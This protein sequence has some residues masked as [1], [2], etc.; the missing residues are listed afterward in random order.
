VFNSFEKFLKTVDL[1]QSLV[2]Q[3][4]F[5]ITRGSLEPSGE[6]KVGG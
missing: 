1:L 4:I 6:Q 5:V 3:V 2:V